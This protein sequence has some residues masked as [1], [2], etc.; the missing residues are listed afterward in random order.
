MNVL[1]MSPAPS[2]LDSSGVRALRRY[3]RGHDRLSQTPF[4][5]E[6]RLETKRRLVGKSKVMSAFKPELFPGF[7]FTAAYSAAT[8]TKAARP[9]FLQI[10]KNVNSGD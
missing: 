9:N 3:R 1:T 5:W 10:N 4:L 6:S 7:R 8:L 2:W